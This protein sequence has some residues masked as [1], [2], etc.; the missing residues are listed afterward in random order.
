MKRHFLRTHLS[1]QVYQE[2]LKLHTSCSAIY[3][4]QYPTCIKTEF[5]SGLMGLLQ[6]TA[7]GQYG[8]ASIMH[9]FI[10]YINAIV[11][12]IRDLLAIYC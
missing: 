7:F 1:P 6:T 8:F 3:K 9:V 12:I 10:L 2:S 4:A 5:D 11:L